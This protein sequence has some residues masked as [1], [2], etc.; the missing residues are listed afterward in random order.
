M[1]YEVF[2]PSIPELFR[3]EV[4]FFPT[5]IIFYEVLPSPSLKNDTKTGWAETP[6]RVSI[7][8]DILT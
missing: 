1:S 7:S 5:F 4:T 3:K 2:S 8:V 6:M